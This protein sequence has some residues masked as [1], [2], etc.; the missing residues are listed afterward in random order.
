MGVS[1]AF[2]VLQDVI[3]IGMA[4]LFGGHPVYGVLAGSA[5]FAGGHGTA[6][7]WGQVAEAHGLPRAEEFGIALATLGLITGGL[8]GGPIAGRLIEKNKLEP[9]SSAGPKAIKTKEDPWTA[10][11]QLP[12]VLG[13][14]LALA[15]CIEAGSLANRFLLSRGILLPGFLT[16]MMVG[17]LLTN[18]ADVVH[19]PLSQGAIDRAGEISLNLFL[20]MSLMAMNL[21]A[22][23]SA[24]GPLLAIVLVQMLVITLFVV[25]VIFRG[26][27]QGLRRRGDLF[28]VRRPGPRCDTCGHRQHERHHG[29]IRAFAKGFSRGPADRRFLHRHPQRRCHPRLPVPDREV[30]RCA[31][32][33]NRLVKLSRRFSNV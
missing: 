18:L 20:V 2:L 9:K 19:V 28:R 16:S 27:G 7:A 30:L 32:D 3:G 12:D 1:A 25:Q 4:W 5:S 11:V 23:A 8:I 26:D 15:I 13:A 24:A 10:T 29:Q 6:I 14:M 21:L 31:G 33:T 22:L 17:I